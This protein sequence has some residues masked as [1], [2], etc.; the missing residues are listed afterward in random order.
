MIRRTGALALLLAVAA[1][2]PALAKSIAVNVRVEGL[3]KTLLDRRVLVDVRKVSS[4]DG[5]GKHKCDGTNNGASSTAGP[6][7]IGAFDLAI[8]QANLTWAG[9]WF[10][11]FEDFSID[12]IGPDSSDTTNNKYWG[13]VVNYKDTD[14]G[15]CQQQIKAGDHV[16]V[17]FNS[18]GHPKL[19]LTGPGHATAGKPFRVT[20]LDGGVG[21]GV[22]GRGGARPQDGPQGP[23]L[24]HAPH[25]RDLPVQGEGERRGPVEH[26]EG[27]GECRLGPVQPCRRGSRR[28][29]PPRLSRWAAAGSAQAARALAAPGSTSRATSAGSRWT[30]LA[31]RTC[32]TAT[33]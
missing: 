10:S 30:P 18:F 14:L 21:E 7:L 23:R 3:H 32:T 25:G 2:A 8:Q 17:A 13:Q 5:T 16:L 29:C 15:G 20:V 19:K 27:R 22:R 31:S 12:R 1:C 26:A 28:R 11:S 33:R 4:G 24:G 6:T 9:K